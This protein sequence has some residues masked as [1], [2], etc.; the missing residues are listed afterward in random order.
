[1]VFEKNDILHKRPCCIPKGSLPFE[2]VGIYI[3]PYYVHEVRLMYGAADENSRVYE[4]HSPIFENIC[5]FVSIGERISSREE[6]ISVHGNISFKGSNAIFKGVRDVEHIKGVI[7]K[8]LGRQG[9]GFDAYVNMAV[10]TSCLG[11]SSLVGTHGS[12]LETSLLFSQGSQCIGLVA[13]TE[14]ERNMVKVKILDWGLLLQESID[15]VKNTCLDF[16]ILYLLF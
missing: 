5:G 4:R 16:I 15:K 8:V 3:L 1:M 6:I 12:L 14:S 7:H 13:K 2:M 9:C 11:K 10:V